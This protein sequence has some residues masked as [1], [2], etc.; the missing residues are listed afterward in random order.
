MN[1]EEMSFDKLCDLF[2]YE[3]KR[4]PL[5]PKN[6]AELLGVGVS[7]LESYRLK[8]GGPR[9]FNP[10]GTRLVRY[11]ERDLLEWLVTSARTSTSAA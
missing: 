4:R 7:T 1:T 2:G 11:A 10:R 9:Y 8:G 3:P 5:D 6:A